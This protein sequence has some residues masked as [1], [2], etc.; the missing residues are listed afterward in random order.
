M[1]MTG[2]S[3]RDFIEGC[4]ISGAVAALSGCRFPNWS[5]GEMPKIALQLYSIN[6]Y[7][8][9]EKDDAGR[10]VRRGRGLEK[11]LE[12][13]AEIGYSGV[14]FAG[15]YGFSPVQL[16]KMLAASGL[17]ASGTHVGNQEFGFKIDAKAGKYEYEPEVLKKTCDFNLGYGNDFICCPGGGNLPP[18][19]DWS[20]SAQPPA[21][22]ERDEFIKRLCGLYNRAGEDAVKMGCRIGLHNHVWEHKIK[23]LDGT[24]Y[25]DYF[26]SN[27]GKCVYMEQ[28][29][30]WTTCAGVDPCGEYRKY[31]GRSLTLHASENDGSGREIKKFDGILGQPGEPGAEPVDWDGLISAAKADGVR[32][33]VVE[34]ERH[35]EDLSAVTPSYGFLK[36]KGLS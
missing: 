15:Y 22:R 26:F 14:Q 29:V 24:S 17:V 18:N 27:T 21:T 5:R 20:V 4:G 30:G 16:R 8:G 19:A 9:G 12:D 7:I 34:C 2:V 25:W 23:M 3:R 6:A 33:F 10:V 31:P 36:G 11:G 28:D 13:V 1:T 32:W 35:F